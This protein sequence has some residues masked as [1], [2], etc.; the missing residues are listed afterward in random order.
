MS[1]TLLLMLA[2]LA[3]T[4]SAAGTSNPASAAVAS[5]AVSILSGDLTVRKANGCSP[6]EGYSLVPTLPG[7]EKT[8]RF[9]RKLWFNL[10]E[11][12]RGGVVRVERQGSHLRAFVEYSVEE[13]PKDRLIP[14]CLYEAELTLLV[15]DLPPGDYELEFI[16]APPPVAPT[17]PATKEK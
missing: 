11:N 4:P 5:P 9:E 17:V 10:R 8:V 13:L 12:V 6:I 7:N 14:T 15:W 2:L 1:A 3:D 16:K